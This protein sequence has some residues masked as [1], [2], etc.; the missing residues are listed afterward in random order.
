M[1]QDLRGQTTKSG[2]HLIESRIAWGKT[3]LKKGGLVYYPQR[4]HVQI[5]EKGKAATPESVSLN[6]LHS[7]VTTFY[8]PEDSAKGILSLVS[9]ASP[10]DLIDTGFEE[11]DCKVKDE[12]L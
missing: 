7:D 2:E 10:Q 8:E 3:Y 4:G 9:T 11:I 12:L 5:T 6:T 1:P